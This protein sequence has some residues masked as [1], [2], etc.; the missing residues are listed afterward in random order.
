MF[1][2]M[3][4]SYS[5]QVLKINPTATTQHP[6]SV[7][8]EVVLVHVAEAQGG[9]SQLLNH[10]LRVFGIKHLVQHGDGRQ[11]LHGYAQLLVAQA[12]LNKFKTNKIF[13]RKKSS[14]AAKVVANTVG[15]RVTT[16]FLTRPPCSCKLKSSFW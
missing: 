10:C 16:A 1:Q 8:V 11:H 12:G 15:E 5:T 9:V 7:P 6:A 13:N 4:S 14:M 2:Y 3:S